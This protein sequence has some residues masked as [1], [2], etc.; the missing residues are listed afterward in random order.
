MEKRILGYVRGKQR[1]HQCG[2]TERNTTTG[3]GLK[4]LKQVIASS[5]TND[6][7]GIKKWVS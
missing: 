4:F 5:K 6:I 7:S 1:K 2:E 3:S